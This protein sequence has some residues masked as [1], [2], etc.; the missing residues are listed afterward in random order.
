[1]ASWAE[2]HGLHELLGD[3]LFEDDLERLILNNRGQEYQEKHLNM[4]K[5]IGLIHT[6]RVHGASSMRHHQRSWTK[7]Y[8][9]SMMNL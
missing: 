1:M 2:G 9:V 5:Y 3:E 8:N 4:G 7:Y 6:D